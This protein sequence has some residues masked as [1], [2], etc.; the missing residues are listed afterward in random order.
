MKQTDKIQK[1]PRSE[2]TREAT[3]RVK[4]WKPPNSLE[5]P[6]APA[7]FV[8]RWIRTEVLGQDDAKN[9]HSRLREGYEPVRAEEYP[10]FKAPTIIDGSLKGVI[11]VGGLIL[12]RISKEL[13]AQRNA[14]YKKR[15]EGQQESVDNE[16]MKDEHPSMPIS[17]ERQSRVTFGGS[18]KSD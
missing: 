11:G 5:A 7:G 4:F 12:C 6:E 9:V 13:V 16:L 10:N 17:K 3:S 18:K 14:Y 1:T 8:H 15:T 2:T